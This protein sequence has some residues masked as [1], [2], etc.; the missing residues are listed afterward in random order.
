MPKGA[1]NVYFY[2]IFCTFLDKTCVYFIKYNPGYDPWIFEYVVS[3]LDLNALT[4]AQNDLTNSPGTGLNVEDIYII[5]VLT[6]R[7]SSCHHINLLSTGGAEVIWKSS[8]HRRSRCPCVCLQV[9]GVDLFC[10]CLIALKWVEWSVTSSWCIIRIYI[11][12]KCEY[13]LTRPPAAN[14][15]VSSTIVRQCEYMRI[16]MGASSWKETP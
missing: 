13:V 15:I 6:P 16:G 3:F 5:E 12:I 2:D 10:T 1:Q 11:Y 4:A 14:T 7:Q 9:Q 8:G